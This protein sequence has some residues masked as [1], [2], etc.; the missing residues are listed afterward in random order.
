[1]IPVH[2]LLSRIRWDPAFGNANFVLG[3]YD[4]VEGRIVHVALG[5]VRFDPGDRFDFVLAGADG[6]EHR[7]PLHRIRE[8][9]REGKCIWQRPEP[10]PRNNRTDGDTRTE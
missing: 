3:Y 7:I 4:R 6:E 9:F 8:V 2:E 10:D 5:D 1:M